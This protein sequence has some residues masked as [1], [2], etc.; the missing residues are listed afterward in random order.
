MKLSHKLFLTIGAVVLF[1]L[2]AGFLFLFFLVG[3]LMD[4]WVSGYETR[5]AGNS[6]QSIDRYFNERQIDIEDLAQSKTFETLLT[7]LVYGNKDSEAYSRAYNL[8]REKIKEFHTLS[9]QWESLSVISKAGDILISND[10][11]RADKNISEYPDEL[12]AFKEGLKGK[13]FY[14]DL[15]TTDNGKDMMIFSAPVKNKF[16]ADN[17]IV[18]AVVGRLNTRNFKEYLDLSPNHYKIL[19]KDG[20][21][22]FSSTKTPFSGKADIEIKEA[23]YGFFK[24]NGWT[25]QI[26]ATNHPGFPVFMASSFFALIFLAILPLIYLAIRRFHTVPIIKL[27][28]YANDAAKKKGTILEGIKPEG[29]MAGLIEAI[30]ELSREIKEEAQVIT[31]DKD[32]MK[33]SRLEIDKFR[34][35]VENSSDHI[36]ITDKSGIIVY[37]NNAVEAITGYKKEE[38]IGSTPAKWGRQMNKA[39]YEK[40]WDVIKNKKQAFFDD[41]INIKK[42]GEKYEA[43]IKIFPILDENGKILYFIGIERNISEVKDIDKAKNDFVSLA[44]HQLCTPLSAINWYAE[45]LLAGDAGKLTD[46]QQS[47]LEQIYHS[48]KR[49]VILVNA[50]LNVSRIDL[51][52]FS[53]EPENIDLKALADSVLSDMPPSFKKKKLNIVKEY[54]KNLAPFYADPTLVRIIFQN[55]LTNAIKYTPEGGTIKLTIGKLGDELLIKLS[56]TGCGM[57]KEQQSKIFTKLFRAD[58][59]RRLE[60]DGTGLGL[61]IVKAIVEGGGGKIWFESEEKKGTTFYITFPITGMARKIGTKRLS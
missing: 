42:S 48:N 25:L 19:R 27:V 34:I 16:A 47:Y 10:Q 32:E 3:S 2:T 30:K 46:D 61:Y 56:D 12:Y 18:G 54:D 14:S 59:V 39:Y 40:M 31:A 22:L 23:G 51:G 24:G 4:G 58:N 5:I 60:T 17:P 44:S 53:I 52:S 38:I 36:F 57:P 33:R 55:I 15:I 43:R 21:I 9:G 37:A 8:G 28:S 6:M 7:E 29:E 45:M 35:A 20:K 50:L 1:A 26:H 13:P 11:E 49:M 41:L